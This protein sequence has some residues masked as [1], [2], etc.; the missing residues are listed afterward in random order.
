MT[1]PETGTRLVV[2][3]SGVHIGS[4]TGNEASVSE[5]QGASGVDLIGEAV[6]NQG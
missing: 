6:P 2:Q 5:F 4:R 1:D 3:P